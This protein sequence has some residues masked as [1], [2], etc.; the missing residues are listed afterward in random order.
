LSLSGSDVPGGIYTWTK[1]DGSTLIGKL[2]SFTAALDDAGI[3]AL[4][5]NIG[6]CKSN[7]VTKRVD[8]ATLGN[9]SISSTPANAT[10][11]L[12]GSVALSVSNLANHT[13]RWKKDGTEIPGPGGASNTLSATQD[14]S[15]T[16]VVTNTVLNCDT[17][18]S[19]LPVIILQPPVVSYTVDATACVGENISFVNSTTTDPRAT[20]VYLWNFGDGTTSPAVNPVKTYT[21]AQNFSTSLAVSYSG[22]T[23]CTGNVS[24]MVNLVNPV[25]PVIT[26]TEPALC[27]QQEATLSIPGTYTSILWDNSATGSST[28]VTGP[29]TYSVETIDANGCPGT[30]DIIIEAKTAPVLTVTA[31]RSAIPSG[32]TTQLK[33]TVEPEITGITYSWLPIET[34]NNASV[35]N[36]IAAP[37]QTTLYTVTG[38]TPDGCTAESEIEVKVEGEGTPEFP[39]AFSPNNDGIADEWNINAPNKPECTLSI[40]DSRGRR[41][42]ENKGVNWDGTYQNKAVPAGAYYYVFGCP[43]TKPLT[44]SVLILK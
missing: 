38:T 8:V 43:D 16:V 28:T 18:T 7:I 17:E 34:L 29:A 9:F 14:G 40:F 5:V 20:A 6:V 39:A 32:D 15:Y 27:A 42:F 30:D 44:G 26:S 3:Y 23:G 19:A 41:V 36:P 22:V 2:Q 12:G 35:F 31:A 25:V 4:Q 10:V 11:C 24:K 33:V 13:Y 1:P 21:T 37:T